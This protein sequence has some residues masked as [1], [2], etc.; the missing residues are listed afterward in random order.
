[1]LDLH[2][3][4]VESG[5]VIS[6]HLAQL[7]SMIPVGSLYF[8]AALVGVGALGLSCWLLFSLVRTLLRKARTPDRLVAVLSGIAALTPVLSPTWQKEAT[9]GGGALVSTALVLLGVWLVLQ[10]CDRNQAGLTPKATRRW[11]FISLVI[12]MA[13]IERFSAGLALFVVVISVA[14]TSNRRPPRVLRPVLFMAV[15]GVTGALSLPAWLRP[16]APSVGADV[17]RALSAVDLSALDVVAT[18]T[19]SLHAWFNEI[20]PISL[21]A[22]VL[23][24]AAALS[25]DELRVW[26]VPVVVL[27]LFELVYPLPAASGLS[28]DPLLALRCLSLAMFSISSSLGIATVLR[29]LWDLPAP[30]VRPGAVLLVAFHM[31]VV[32]VA[33]EEAGFVADRSEHHAARAWTNDALG[34]APHRATLLVHSPALAW[35]LWAAQT[36]EGQRPDV[37]VVPS[38][39]LHHG[40]VVRNLLPSEPKVGNLLRDYALKGRATE[41]SL[42]ALADVRPLLVELDDSWSERL[43]G[44]LRVQGAWLRYDPQPLGK[45]DRAKRVAHVFANGSSP[46][47][48]GAELNSLVEDASSVTV[49]VNTL[50]EHAAALSLLGMHRTV[51][52][53]LDGIEA[54][55]PTDPFVTG[56]R[57]RLA[58]AM[59]RKSRSAVELR[60]LLRY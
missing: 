35:R 43:V 51:Y 48:W 2:L 40:R 34:Q 8:R 19:L 44:H 58:Y 36:L 3:A 27:G 7:M 25:R 6:T 28:G 16:L 5:G 18:R 11:L 4:A 47:L 37:L 56:A 30:L 13:F 1:M 46:V 26:I 60:D 55:R 10:V 15:L 41:F 12:A 29:F 31:S 33:C 52:P 20:G 23:G 39:L 32:A 22:A 17:G 57:V 38:P 24:L 14:M 50:K 49:V 54:L 42:S 53:L 21:A 9:V 59:D 45:S